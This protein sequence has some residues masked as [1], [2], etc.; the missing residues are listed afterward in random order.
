MSE[1]TATGRWASWKKKKTRRGGGGSDR[2][3]ELTVRYKAARAT[4]AVERDLGRQACGAA[5][6]PGRDAGPRHLRLEVRSPTGCRDS[7]RDRGQLLGMSS[8]EATS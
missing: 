8:P 7:P 2:L 1:D 4:R 3:H 6:L 5:G